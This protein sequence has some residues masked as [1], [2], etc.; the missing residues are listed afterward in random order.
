MNMIWSSSSRVPLH[1]NVPKKKNKNRSILSPATGQSVGQQPQQGEP[2]HNIIESNAGHPSDRAPHGGQL[3][4]RRRQSTGRVVQRPTPSSRQMQVFFFHFF[5]SFISSSAALLCR[6]NAIKFQ[7][8]DL[9]FVILDGR[10]RCARLPP[11]E[12]VDGGGVARPA[13]DAALP[14]G[15]GPGRGQF[16][17]DA[18][19]RAGDEAA[20]ARN[21]LRFGPHEHPQVHTANRLGLWRAAVLGVE[22]HREAEGAVPIQNRQ[23]R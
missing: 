3:H 20:A 8:A 5:F 15:V 23:R 6:R 19:E 9:L 13:G 12:A 2:G 4:V 10:H 17:V 21:V 18:V 22:R 7:T 16:P 11:L 14:S 1:C